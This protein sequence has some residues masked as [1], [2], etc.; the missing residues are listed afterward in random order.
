ME[1]ELNNE[2]ESDRDTPGAVS[3][4]QSAEASSDPVLPDAD[5]PGEAVVVKAKSFLPAINL[6]EKTDAR[7]G[8]VTAVDDDVPDDDD[9]RPRDVR[10]SEVAAVGSSKVEAKDV[11]VDSGD[12]QEVEPPVVVKMPVDPDD[13]LP[14]VDDP[15]ENVDP[16]TLE[17]SWYILKVQVNRETS[18]CETLKRRVQQHGLGDYFGDLLVP[19]EDVREYTKAG[20]QRIVKRKLYPGYIMV[21]MAITEDSW[22]L[23]RDTP[24]IGDFTGVGGRPAPLA[25]EEIDRILKAARPVVDETGEKKEDIKTAIKHKMGDRVR[26]KDGNFENFEGDV[27]AIDERNGRITV[28]I[29]IFGRLN[30]VE[31]DHWQVE[32]I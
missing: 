11:V 2:I 14:A 20:K 15:E 3:A 24:G 17:K 28:L 8:K 7:R 6:N 4:E 22:W 23:V 19:T 32:A 16:A 9:V 21:H 18:I 1:D 12:A 5:L 27:S 13:D 29:N 26:V 25:A 10:P 30:P 31:L